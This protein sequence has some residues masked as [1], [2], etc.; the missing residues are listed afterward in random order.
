MAEAFIGPTIP[1]R[2]HNLAVMIGVIES[3]ELEELTPSNG[4][5]TVPSGTGFFLPWRIQD[6][7]PGA[8]FPARRQISADARSG[9]T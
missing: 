4:R 7:L 9:R 3:L 1:E 2:A 5:S 6:P 8:I